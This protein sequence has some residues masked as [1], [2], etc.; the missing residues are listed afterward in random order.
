MIRPPRFCDH[1]LSHF[2]RGCQNCHLRKAASRARRLRWDTRSKERAAL[3][4]VWSWIGLWISY[5]YITRK[6]PPLG[7]WWTLCQL[8]TGG[9]KKS[10]WP[11]MMHEDLQELASS[12]WM[13]ARSTPQGLWKT[14]SGFA[15]RPRGLSA[16]TPDSQS[17]HLDNQM[18]ML[19]DKH[20]LNCLLLSLL[21]NKR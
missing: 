14:I 19:I 9:W 8:T 13:L 18:K 4:W 10:S 12:N 1:I 3:S 21:Y 20:L 7:K 5:S 16:L 2:P 15:L 6:C 17:L 11:Y